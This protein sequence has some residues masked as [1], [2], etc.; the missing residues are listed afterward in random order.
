L[1]TRIDS[2]TEAPDERLKRNWRCRTRR[3][4]RSAQQPSSCSSSLGHARRRSCKSRPSHHRVRLRYYANLYGEMGLA[5]LEARKRAFLFYAV[6]FAKAYNITGG[7]ADVTGELADALL[8][9]PRP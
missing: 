7:D 1:C 5:P 2:Q 6:P 9:D 8:L 3:R 4:V